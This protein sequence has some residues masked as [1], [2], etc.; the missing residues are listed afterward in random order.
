MI[1]EDTR[2]EK[3]IISFTGTNR[4]SIINIKAIEDS[5]LKEIGSGIKHLYLNMLGIHFLDTY[6]YNRLIAVNNAANLFGTEFRLFNVS[7]ELH[8]I[9]GL[10]NKTNQ[11]KFLN[12]KDEKSVNLSLNQ[13]FAY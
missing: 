6:S 11:I 9:F 13:K 8:E 5:L 7:D 4:L 10:L 3:L 2:G 1:S 12:P